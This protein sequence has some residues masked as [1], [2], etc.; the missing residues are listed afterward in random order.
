[1][2]AP[3]AR[4]G[5]KALVIAVASLVGL[6]GIAAATSFVALSGSSE[7]ITTKLPA[8]T[9]VVVTAYLDPAAS[10]KVN[11]FRLTSAFPSLGDE[12]EV[13][14]RSGDW[15]DSL[16]AETGLTHDDLAWVGSQVAVVV[17]LRAD[18][19]P[20][21]AVLLDT[22]NEADAEVSLR[23][24]RD[25]RLFGGAE[26]SQEDHDG[27]PVWAGDDGREQTYMGI[28]DGTVVI[29]ND[30]GTFDG[31]VATANG[32]APALADDQD[33]VD[34][35][36]GLPEG[37]LGMLYVAPADLLAVIER[38]QGPGVT[39]LGTAAGVDPN[40][41]RG[42]GI[43][44]SA[45]SDALA[46]DAEVTIDPSKL[47]PE[48]LDAYG[49][50]DHENTQITMVPADALGFAGLQHLDA[51][52]DAAIAELPSD[53]RDALDRSGLEPAISSLTGDMALEV[54]K[55]V[56][57]PTPAGA[58]LM[59]TDDETAMN[60]A[61]EIVAKT[62]SQTLSG[63]PRWATEDHDGVT[64][65]YLAEGDDGT[66][67]SPA[68]AVFDGSGLIASSR[69]KAFRIIDTAHGAPSA[70]EAEQVIAALDDVPGSEN[71]MYLDLEGLVNAV[72]GRRCDGPRDPG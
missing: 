11:L 15:V 37:R 64:V 3:P 47:T 45:E 26:W 31:I 39:D 28:V 46:L 60:S 6:A 33:F 22:T 58:I 66:G 55:Q 56:S 19:V 35:M 2:P 27:V 48:Q 21:I 7:A 65:T 38:M 57:A 62:F 1:M 40:A 71:L 16:L 49:A 52:L 72:A 42:L 50:D 43:T 10:Q 18:D 67:M 17:D 54:S 53:Q 68:Y 23:A 25:G 41:I 44:L 8:D 36:A 24:L 51:G 30:A 9:D 13:T 61:M 20:A 70:I 12:A 34:T 14:G 29:T 5:R 32:E 63:A 69:D 4:R 59:G